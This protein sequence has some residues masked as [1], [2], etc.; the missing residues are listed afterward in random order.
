MKCFIVNNIRLCSFRYRKD[1]QSK[2]AVLFTACWFCQK[3]FWCLIIGAH[4]RPLGSSF[5]YRCGKVQTAR[6]HVQF[7]PLELYKMLMPAPKPCTPVLFIVHRYIKSTPS[8][9]G[10][11]FA[12]TLL[13]P[14]PLITIVTKLA[15]EK[16]ILIKPVM[17]YGEGRKRKNAAIYPRLWI[18]TST[19]PFKTISHSTIMVRVD[20]AKLISNER[21]IMWENS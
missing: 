1:W 9:L 13:L 11:L 19:C 5:V 7:F 6:Q 16:W 18:G 10:V 14:W 21:Y 2:A 12:L 15:G 20:Y 3:L 8:V 4:A 17:S